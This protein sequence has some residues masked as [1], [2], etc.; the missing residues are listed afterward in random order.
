MA[1]LENEDVSNGVGSG[2]AMME[3]L[4]KA[5][6]LLES[7]LDSAWNHII[8]LDDLEEYFHQLRSSLKKEID[9]L[10]IAKRKLE[11]EQAETEAIIS[12]REAAV[13]AKE[14]ALLDRLQELKDNAVSV[15]AQA[16]K[17]HQ[18]ASPNLVDNKGVKE[19][20]VSIS[21]NVDTKTPVSVI[22]GS[23]PD[24]KSGESAEQM[25]AKGHLNSILKQLCEQM[26][27]KGLVKYISEN[28]KNLATLCEELPF[29]LKCATE[30]ARM[31]LDALEGFYP[32]DQST[33]Q[34]NEN[35]T[36]LQGLRRSCLILMESAVPVLATTEPGDHH[37]LS[38]EIKQQAKA[39]A[40]QWKPKMADMKLDASNG[41][42]LE[43]QAFLQLLATFCIPS[44]FNEDELCKII[45]I[46]SRRRQTPE[47]CRSLGLTHKM[48]GWYHITSHQ[49]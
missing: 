32:P 42:T 18:V 21:A 45:L 41:S 38:S 23:L 7:H 12:G 43:A 35:D 26:D 16:H 33:S 34:G 13:S 6:G 46:V 8:K 3:Q 9:E 29:A 47:L 36:A 39:I 48:P 49:P 22:E 14:Q 28:R 5:L 10:E 30:P 15:I 17:R 31:V 27:T 25:P 11:E 44:E 20:K 24:S 2:E 1:L 19:G 40:N 37:P 4:R